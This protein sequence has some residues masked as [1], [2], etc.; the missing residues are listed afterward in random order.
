M[1]RFLLTLLI[2]CMAVP[3]MA[4]GACASGSEG[5]AQVASHHGGHGSPAGEPAPQKAASHS[6]IGCIPP[7][8]GVGPALAQVLPPAAAAFADHLPAAPLAREYA[9]IPPPPRLTA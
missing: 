3:T 4:G 1:I 2:A 5:P 6:C 9:P 7:S 8:F